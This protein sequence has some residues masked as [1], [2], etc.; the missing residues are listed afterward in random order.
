MSISRHWE[1]ISKTTRVS[2]S[3]LKG[4]LEAIR[5][6]KEDDEPDETPESEDESEGSIEP[7]NDEHNGDACACLRVTGQVSGMR[8]NCRAARGLEKSQE[9]EDGSPGGKG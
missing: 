4:A 7:E 3:T 9:T 6:P 1:T 5:S 2:D 8:Q